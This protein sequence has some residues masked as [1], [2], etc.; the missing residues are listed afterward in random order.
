MDLKQSTTTYNT[1][2]YDW[3]ANS[4]YL[5]TAVPLTVVIPTGGNSEA[6]L[7]PDGFLKSGLIVAKYDSGA[8][9]DLYGVYVSDDG[10]ATDLDDPAGIILDGF[11][12]R[13]NADGSLLTTVAAG[14]VLLAGTPQQVFTGKMPATLDAD[15]TTT[16]AIVTADLPAGFVDLT[17]TL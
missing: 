7:Y 11:E 17:G 9:L 10:T 14:S 5:E 1:R 2:Q 13:K 3:L 15:G 16:H 4:F 12:V 6:E 8:N